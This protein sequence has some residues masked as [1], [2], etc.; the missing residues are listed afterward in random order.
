MHG[1]LIVLTHDV[2]TGKAGDVAISIHTLF[3]L[4]ALLRARCSVHIRCIIIII[5][6]TTTIIPTIIPTSICLGLEPLRRCC[7]RC[8]ICGF[9][10]AEAARKEAGH[11]VHGPAALW[12]R[13]EHAMQ[14]LKQRWCEQGD[15][16]LARVEH[17]SP[18]Q[19]CAVVWVAL[20]RTVPGQVGKQH[21][22]QHKAQA[23]HVNSS[24]VLE[25]RLTVVV[26]VAIAAAAALCPR[27]RC[28]GRQWRRQRGVAGIGG[29]LLRGHVARRAWEAARGARANATRQPKVADLDVVAAVEQDVL[30]LDVGVDDVVGVVE[31]EEGSAELVHPPAHGGLCERDW[32]AGL[33][34]VVEVAV[35]G[36][37]H[38][39]ERG[40]RA[41]EGIKG[42][43][44]VWVAEPRAEGHLQLCDVVRHLLDGD[45]AAAD[46]VV[47][48]IHH[49]ISARP[50]LA[51]EHEPG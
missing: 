45:V 46:A 39:K 11:A 7:W 4:L 15:W 20:C 42:A 29:E 3:V 1:R 16:V 12:G 24:R 26:A 8:A 9:C 35:G 5:I 6:T 47:R 50:E 13:V 31:V 51:G 14:R 32:G 34:A 18:A 19:V 21:R 41:V 49:G 37:L 2:V 22:V 36:Q 10:C 33:E 43:D 30:G 23:P 28:F 27:C 38:G 17:G 40:R 44:N 25:E 48:L